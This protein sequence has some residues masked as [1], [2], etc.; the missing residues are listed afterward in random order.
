MGD[1]GQTASLNI[2]QIV[3][4]VDVPDNTN[5]IMDNILIALTGIFALAPV[6]LTAVR[7]A[8][9]FGT[10]VAA[11]MQLV[12]NALFAYP[13]IGRYLFPH[14]DTD[15][16]LVQ[17]A[18]L[19]TELVGVLQEVQNN[20]NKTL[21]SVM[22][23]IDEFLAFASLGNFSA[24]PPSLPDQ[25]NYLLYGFNTYLV[26]AALA[27]ND[28]HAVLALD[29]NPLQLATNGTKLNYD[30]GCEAFNEVGVCGQWW[31][32]SESNIAYGLDDF[33]H[34]NRDMNEA[35]TQI[36]SNYTTGEL[37][38]RNAYM[39][40]LN[41]NYGSPVNVTVNAAGISTSCLSQL[42]TLRWDMRCREM[43]TRSQCEFLDAPRQ[44]TWMADCGSHSYFSVM[45]E[46]K[47]CVP[48]S[49]LGPLITQTKVELVSS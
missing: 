1:S 3:Q 17:I 19:K 36:L 27:G 4:I 7:G 42:Q 34:M 39:C 25:A 16:K 29:T 35:L 26:S 13:Q 30:I 48:K 24:T 10:R 45:D 41:G 9:N 18:A 33:R 5:L 12:E 14:G 2:D 22:T 46:E 11:G 21:C 32:D 38:F 43:N 28:V 31:W 49:Y 8:V 37:L 20:L 47:Y 6:G 44:N 23:N 15:S 40:N